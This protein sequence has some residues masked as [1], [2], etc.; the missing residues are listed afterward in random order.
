MKSRFAG[1]RC[2]R[3]PGTGLA[4]ARRMTMTETRMEEML[5]ERFAAIDQRF[6]GLEKRLARVEGCVIS[7]Q[8]DVAIVKHAVTA[9]LQKVR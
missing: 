3:A 2:L 9:V 5:D 6:A 8:R 7:L 4:E 1:E